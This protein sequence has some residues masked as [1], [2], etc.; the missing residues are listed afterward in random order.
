MITKHDFD[1]SKL[2]VRD[3]LTFLSIQTLPQQEGVKVILDC[4]DK[5]KTLGTSVY[6]LPMAQVQEVINAFT[7][8]VTELFS[9][10]QV[11]PTFWDWGKGDKPDE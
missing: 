7:E 9:S 4:A 6:D 2:T 8:A 1:M 11:P 3:Y 5:A 10:Q